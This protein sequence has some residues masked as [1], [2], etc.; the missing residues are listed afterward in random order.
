MAIN[1]NNRVYDGFTSTAAGMNGGLQPNLIAKNQVAFL[2][3]M[4]N[5]GGCP[6]TRPGFKQLNA[7]ISAPN[8]SYNSSG[9]RPGSGAVGTRS[10]DVWES[11]L[12]QGA[13]YYAHPGGEECLM[14]SIGGRLFRIVPRTYYADITEVPIP[15][16]RNRDTL[17]LAYMV[18]AD[19]FHITQ[20]GESLPIIF[21]GIVARR[22]NVDEVPVGTL[23]AYGMGRLVVVRPQSREI[24]FGDLFGSHGGSDPGASVLKFTETNYL[25][26]GGSASIPFSLGEIVA[27]I[28]YPQQDTASGNGELLI[29]AEKGMASFF[30]SLPR[31]RWK[32]SNFQRLGLLEVGGRGHRAFVPVNED[33]WFRSGDGW[34]T[35]RQA[36]SEIHGW[37]Q[38]PLSTEV[39]EYTEN[40]TQSLLRYA[41]AVHFDN[42]LIATCTPIPNKGAAAHDPLGNILPTGRLY[43]EG[44]VVLDFDVLSSFGQATRPAWD[45]HWTGLKTYQLI[46]GTFKGNHRA[47]AFG[48]DDGGTN[49]LF[50]I[51]KNA[52]VDIKGS[53]AANV[54]IQ[55]TLVTRAMDF[56]EPFNEDEVLDADMWL[57]N[58]RT[59]T[60]LQTFY[61]PDQY[62]EWVPWRPHADATCPMPELEAIGTCGATNCGGCPTI[63]PGF[64]PR[65]SFGKPPTVC[66]ETTKRN[67]R[68]CYDFQTKIVM[69]GNATIRK[70][71]SMNDR[72]V[73][74]SMATIE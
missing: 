2:E 30:L 35:Y 44:F 23:M 48:Q 69:T 10:I 37:Q 26:E 58:I 50:E 1:D 59:D 17:S 25:A 8:F 28:F 4:V 3:N 54:P 6:K 62:P 32:E 27:A 53:P 31:E 7:N 40:D 34:R 5:R 15:D 41:S 67:T 55:G 11:G 64:K 36:R 22:A 39:R 29:F 49:R 12:F 60:T 38:L 18:Q 20:D 73:E 13:S 14:A 43:H 47:F 24:L 72:L 63:K 68:R 51:T 9:F 71:R 46:E 57:D 45:G 61:K 70:F 33:I 74:K 66:D 56:D 65:L 42:R 16:K 19:R 21:D 52:V